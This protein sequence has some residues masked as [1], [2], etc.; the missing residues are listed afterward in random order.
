MRT[1]T[2]ASAAHTDVEPLSPLRR[3]ADADDPWFKDL[4]E[5]KV[6]SYQGSPSSTSE[7]VLQAFSKAQQ[8]AESS[9]G[10]TTVTMLIDEVGLAEISPFNPLKVLHSLLE[11]SDFDKGLDVAVV[12]IS[13]WCLVRKSKRTE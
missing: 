12:C 5:V 9:E 1:H 4:D 6:V 8:Y 11:N 7:G 3:G 10:R 2:L 13:N